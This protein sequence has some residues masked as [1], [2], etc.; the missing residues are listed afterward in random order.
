VAKAD[1]RVEMCSTCHYCKADRCH[2]FPPSSSETE[3]LAVAMTYYPKVEE[4]QACGEY[5][6]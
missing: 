2:R 1:W 4:K 6:P 5:K 3:P